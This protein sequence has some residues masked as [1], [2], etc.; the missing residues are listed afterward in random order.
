MIASKHPSP[1]VFLNNFQ[2]KVG[3]EN[4]FNDSHKYERQN[5]LEEVYGSKSVNGGLVT[6]LAS[7]LL[8]RY[9]WSVSPYYYADLSRLDGV[10]VNVPKSVSISGNNES[11]KSISL[12]VFLEIE[13]QISVDVLTGVVLTE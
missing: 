8:N 4:I 5:F 2:V 13:K 9:D 3:G 11:P 6:G 7:G 10:S 1:Y 12:M